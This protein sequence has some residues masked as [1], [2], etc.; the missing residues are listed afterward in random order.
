MHRTDHITELLHISKLLAKNPV[1]VPY[2]IP[3]DYFHHLSDNIIQRI[4]ALDALTP[5]EET[6]ALSPLLSSLNKRMPYTM[7]EAYF[8][9]LAPSLAAAGTNDEEIA[10]EQVETTSPLLLSLRNQPTYQLP[11]GYFDQL[12]HSILE[13]L[14]PA[15]QARVIPIGFGRKIIR[16]AAAA[17]VAAVIA[18]SG[19]L[20]WQRQQPVT[21]P[22]SGS[23]ADIKQA[24]NKELQDFI[25]QN[26]IVLPDNST[27]VTSN[28]IR[29]EDVRTML[30]GVPDTEL[31]QYL[32]QQPNLK[33][34]TLNNFN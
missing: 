9:E 29:A 15:S 2:T 3:P 31:Q 13:K 4:K 16:Y 30:A 7:P 28:E 26:T 33:D 23:L 12:P 24:S 34:P 22:A 10:G 1:P 14:S 18:V 21:A 11:P 8:R 25:D 27:T 17:C 32:E 19:W 6:A 20:L 5:A